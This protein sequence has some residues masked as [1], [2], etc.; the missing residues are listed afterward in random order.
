MKKMFVA[1]TII[2]MCML[3]F[4]CG[5]QPSISYNIS[6]L[7]LNVGTTYTLDSSNIKI[8]DS[9]SGYQVE[10]EDTEVASIEGLKITPIKAGETKV[11]I[12][13]VNNKSVKFEIKL[14]VTAIVYADNPT[15]SKQDIELNLQKMPSTINK[16][17]LND[18]CNEL[19]QLVECSPAGI[20]EYDYTTGLVTAKSSGVAT[21]VVYY[22]N[23]NVGFRVKVTD[24]VYVTSMTVD[25]N[26]VMVG[27]IGLLDYTCFPDFANTYRFYCS[28]DIISVDN[29]G[30]YTAK[31]IGIATVYYEYI[32][33]AGSTPIAGSFKVTVIDKISSFNAKLVDSDNTQASYYLIEEIYK[34]I[35]DLDENIPS[36]CL[37]LSSNVRFADNDEFVY[38]EDM[39]WVAN[40]NFRQFGNIDIVITFQYGSTEEDCVKSTISSVYVNGYKDFKIM[41]F[42]GGYNLRSNI[43]SNV[44]IYN[45]VDMNNAPIYFEWG[46]NNTRLYGYDMSIYMISEGDESKVYLNSQSIDQLQVGEKTLYF[47]LNGKLIDSIVIQVV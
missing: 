34:I 5:K 38:I 25:D 35:V 20:V 11:I 10:I 42:S 4:A 30:N 19:P 32:T 21:V 23:C 1:L 13:L 24:I 39:G 17:Q 46:I 28:S 3:A 18:G 22:R 29:D 47:E 41:A 27:S 16:I 2:C 31:N 40:I 9:K 44:V 33:S 12:S 15:V 37:K 26:I 45:R 36:K 14:L 8:T 43:D 7:I 6:E